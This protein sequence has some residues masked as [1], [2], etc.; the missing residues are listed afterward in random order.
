MNRVK[1]FYIE[2]DFADLAGPYNT[3]IPQEQYF[4]DRVI[5]DMQRGN[6]EYRIRQDNEGMI[7][8]Q[9]KGMILSK[10]DNDN[11]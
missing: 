4:L 7:Y 5:G 2:E 8:I 11:D 9:R 1:K 6:I 10:K 3:C